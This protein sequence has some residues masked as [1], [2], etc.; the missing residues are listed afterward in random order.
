[1]ENLT[2]VRVIKIY[3]IIEDYLNCLN[4]IQETFANNYKILKESEKNAKQSFK[5]FITQNKE[6]DFNS[7]TPFQIKELK[8]IIKKV[9]RTEQAVIIFPQ[10]MLV[11]IVS[12]YDYLVGQL[13]QFI[14]E[15]N[16]KLLQESNSQISY[17]DLFT[18]NDIGAIRDKIIQDKVE[19]ILR[20][21]HDEQ[22]DDLQK[23]SGVKNLKG[24]H[25][26]KEFVEIT[27]RR[28]L[29]V[30]CKGCVSEQYIKECQ[31][32]G[33]VKL[34][35]KGENLNVDEGYFLRAYF[36]FYM[37]GALLTQ[38]IIR[39]L[40]S[41]EN[42]LG[43][44]DTILTN[45][46]YETL[47][48]EKYDLT[49]ELSEFA[50][51]GS[52][53]HACRLDEVYFVLNHAQAHKWKGNQEECNKILTQFDFSAMTSDILV[54]KFAL[55][56]NIEQVVEHMYKVGNTSNIMRKDSYASWVIFKEMR[57]KVEFKNAYKN[58]FGEDLILE[59]LTPEENKVVK[60]LES[61]LQN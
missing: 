59:S 47:E 29:F 16:P 1:M 28:N 33:L 39:Q 24:V 18:Y 34:P 43:E 49:I 19:T 27:Q 32:V 55:E 48:E 57:K 20:K 36:V 26:W 25:F 10:S 2:D 8:S 38:V 5:N 13:I 31:N 51:A 6:P 14:Y 15:V 17:K 60:D 35:S 21:S 22:I 42:L 53:K 44:I 12:Q 37:M 56:D 45:I 46:I 9:G 52:T 54:A 11:S 40:L 61:N 7:L 4:S 41:K 58:I 50:M 23:I 30:H 3:R